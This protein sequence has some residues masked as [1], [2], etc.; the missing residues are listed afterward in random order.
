VL[1]LLSILTRI[2]NTLRVGVA[3]PLIIDWAVS[4]PN[5][6]HTEL[7]LEVDDHFLLP[8][9]AGIVI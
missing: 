4:V 8:P 5:D 2:R 3:T 6:G 7:E 9:L 1:F